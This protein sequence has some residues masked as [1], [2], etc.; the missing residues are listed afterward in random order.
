MSNAQSAIFGRERAVI[1]PGIGII[2]TWGTVA[3]VPADGTPG[4]APSCRFQNIE[5]TTLDT[6]TYWNIGT[7]ASCNFDVGSLA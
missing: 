4:F 3:E 5:G 2:S 6:I 1:I 7:L